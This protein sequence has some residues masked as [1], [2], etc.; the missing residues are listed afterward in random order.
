M[1]LLLCRHIDRRTEWKVV[2]S[3]DDFTLGCSAEATVPIPDPGLASKEVLFQRRGDRYL[4]RDLAEKNRVLLGDAITR[5]ALVRNGDRIRVGRVALVFFESEGGTAGQVDLYREEVPAEAGPE[6]LVAEPPPEPELEEPGGEPRI[7]RAAWIGILALALAAGFI[8]GALLLPGRPRETAEAPPRGAAAAGQAVVTTGAPALA[9][10][11]GAASPR[12]PASAPLGT[13]PAPVPPSPPSPL[14]PPAPPGPKAA[15]P[16]RP[17]PSPVFA[18]P[19]AAPPAA[20]PRPLAEALRDLKA[21]LKPRTEERGPPLPP[22]GKYALGV[23]QDPTASRVALHRLFLD[24]AGRPPTRAEAR[25]LLPLAHEQRWRRVDEA[26]ARERKGP[27][28]APPAAA[29]LERLLGRKPSSEDVE[30]VEGLATRERPAAFWITALEEYRSPGHRRP[31][32]GLLLARSLIV[33]LLDRPPASA[34]EVDLVV[35]ALEA[36]TAVD[37]V[38]RVLALS[39]ESRLPRDESAG[40]PPWWEEE[41]HRFLLRAPTAKERED[42]P[43]ILARLKKGARRRWLT[44]ALAGLPE[45]KTY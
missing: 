22:P 10:A 34:A 45:Y 43:R 16:A 2:V 29:E 44:L 32:L 26:A 13:A 9:P 42:V 5:E 39:P 25:E 23:L 14:S 3:G 31:R 8:L 28:P 15:Q 35:A 1:P 21:E 40:P 18:P 17:G 12:G 4:L 27:P 19:L 33:D 30:E 20:E 41:A 6:P 11:A 24:L 37:A 36:A 38:A 7:P